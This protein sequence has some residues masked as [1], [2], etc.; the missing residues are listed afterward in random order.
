[1]MKLTCK[2]SHSYHNV[3]I[4]SIDIS[5]Y[6]SKTGTWE[7]DCHEVASIFKKYGLLIIKDPRVNTDQNNNFLDLMERYFMKRSK[8]FDN[9]QKTID[10]S[11]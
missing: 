6:L 10:F 8:Q 3:K 7:Q 5:N 2:L 11:P 9:G 4:P 1:M